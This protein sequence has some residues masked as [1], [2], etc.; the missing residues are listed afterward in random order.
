MNAPP[1]NKIP[2]TSQAKQQNSK[3]LKT[4]SYHELLEIKDRQ[5]HLLASKNRLQML[6]DKGRRIRESYEKLLAEIHSRDEVEA[7][8]KLLGELNIASKGKITLNNL[9]WQGRTSDPDSNASDLLDSDDEQEMDP[10]RVIAQGSLHQ[11]QVKILPP[12]ATLITHEDLAEIESFRLD[13][14]DSFRTDQSASSSCSGQA[15]GSNAVAA[16]IIEIDVVTLVG[17]PPATMLEQHALYLIE[18]TELQATAT[19][20]EKFKPFR[21]TVSNVHDPAKERTRKKGKHWENTAAT[22]P[23]IQHKQIQLVPLAES[24]SLQLDYMQRVKELRIKQ[25]EQR[26]A[27]QTGMRLPEDFVL[28]SKASF[29]KYRNPQVDYLIEGKRSASED[30]EVI[31]PT[32]AQKIT[33]GISYSVYE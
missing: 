25:A 27:R 17:K 18:K 16:E 20:R 5:S 26:L 33:T 32:I 15:D 31:D 6:P 10:L 23:L 12:H 2:G 24:T 13:S 7:T 9:E 11:R 19:E 29:Q 22:P 1:L 4:L 8:A 30:S 28:K 21:T 14:L 3:D